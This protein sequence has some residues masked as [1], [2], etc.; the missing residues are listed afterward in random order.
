MKRRLW[1]PVVAAIRWP[2]PDA[3]PAPS[4]L[5]CDGV[6]LGL[7]R[8]LMAQ[9][10]ELDGVRPKVG[11]GV[12]LAPTAVLIGNVAIGDHATGTLASGDASAR[13]GSAG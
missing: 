5:L 8:S 9:I 10:V 6:K 7:R 1:R 2:A 11:V 12:Y 4:Y 3:R 13:T